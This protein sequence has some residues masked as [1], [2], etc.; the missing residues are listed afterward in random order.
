MHHIPSLHFTILYDQ[1]RPETVNITGGEK[2][3]MVEAGHTCPWVNVT[4]FLGQLNKAEVC[5]TQNIVSQYFPFSTASGVL[6]WTQMYCDKRMS[7]A[8]LE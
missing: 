6:V 5:E 8:S 3:I 2:E 4:I 1:Y 7:I